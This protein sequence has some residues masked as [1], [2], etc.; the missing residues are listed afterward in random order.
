MTMTTTKLS[1][2]LTR[3]ATSVG[4]TRTPDQ[5]IRAQHGKRISDLMIQRYPILCTLLSRHS[6]CF[7]AVLA[8]LCA[9][10]KHRVTLRIGRLV[11]FSFGSDALRQSKLGGL[12]F[13]GIT[14]CL[15]QPLAL[16][17]LPAAFMLRQ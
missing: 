15:L 12:W 10:I 3:K 6:S 14:C 2:Q 4:Q 8:S 13:S 11:L 9:N 5:Y 1:L 17:T 16:L 7:Y